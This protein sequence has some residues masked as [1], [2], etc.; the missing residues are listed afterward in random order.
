[1]INYLTVTFVVSIRLTDVDVAVKLLTWIKMLP[2]YKLHGVK[3]LHLMV[4]NDHYSTKKVAIY[5]NK[6]LSR[7]IKRHL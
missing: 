6:C 2:F 1:L 5:K 7:T 4:T 3:T